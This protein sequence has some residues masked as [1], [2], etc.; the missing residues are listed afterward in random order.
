MPTHF[1]LFSVQH[2]A[3]MCRPLTLT[4]E[5]QSLAG[6]TNHHLMIALS[7]IGQQGD[8]VAPPVVHVLELIREDASMTSCR[9]ATDLLAAITAFTEALGPSSLQKEGKSSYRSMI[10]RPH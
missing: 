6:T 7:C 8:L 3:F 9:V 5:S 10:T 1:M 2:V 4:R